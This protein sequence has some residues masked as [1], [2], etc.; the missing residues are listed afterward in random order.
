MIVFEYFY[1][2]MEDVFTPLMD[3]SHMVA[4]DELCSV[5]VHC[6]QYSKDKV[7]CMYPQKK[8]ELCMILQLTG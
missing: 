1:E 3:K 8:Y 7:R 4:H 2:K 5:H 6:R